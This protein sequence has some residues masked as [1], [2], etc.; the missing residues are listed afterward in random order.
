MDVR[1]WSRSNAHYGRELVNSGLRG[2]ASGR[3]SF[4]QGLRLGPILNDSARR[5]CRSAAAG[6]FMGLLSGY[7]ANRRRGTANA[8]K[9]AVAGGALGFGAAM[10]W[11]NRCLAASVGSGAIHNMGRARDQHWLERH[12]ID[13]A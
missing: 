10:V 7:L 13:Y 8:L 12:P 4:L 2:A 1:Q 11:R 6:V 5:A 9:Y 3:D